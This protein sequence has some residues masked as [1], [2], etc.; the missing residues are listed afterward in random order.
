[1]KQ[2][3]IGEDAVKAFGGQRQFQ[4]ILV[5]DFAATGRARH[6]DKAGRA[7]Q[8]HRPMAQRDEGLQ[9][10]AGSASQIQDV[11]GR[12][13]LDMPQQRGDVLADIV[14]APR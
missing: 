7:V 10:A 8:P 9:V 2:H 3:G 5:P 13:A 12:L 1:M 4:E 14:V 6:G 11:V